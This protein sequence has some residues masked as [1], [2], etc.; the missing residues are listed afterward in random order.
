M[1]YSLRSLNLFIPVVDVDDS[2]MIFGVRELPYERIN[3]TSESFDIFS[4][5]EIDFFFREYFLCSC[6]LIVFEIIHLAHSTILFHSLGFRWLSLWIFTI[7][8]NLNWHVFDSGKLISQCVL[9][10]PLKHNFVN[11]WK[12][13]P[14][15]SILLIFRSSRLC[16][17]KFFQWILK[18]IQWLQVSL[19]ED[20]IKTLVRQE[21]CEGGASTSRCTKYDNISF[22]TGRFRSL[23]GRTKLYVGYQ[24]FT[25]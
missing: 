6:V 18:V 7:D 25:V 4:A 9:I 12:L 24:T 21:V 8:D 23:A 15:P 13:F 22:P 5:S 1:F 11:L 14:G 17:D 10:K 2:C 19:D 16:I 3:D 20:Q